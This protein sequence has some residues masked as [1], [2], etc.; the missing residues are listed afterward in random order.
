LKV[1]SLVFFR[2]PLLLAYYSDG[3]WAL[4]ASVGNYYQPSPAP[5]PGYLSKP[6]RRGRP[7]NGL[8]VTND[9]TVKKHTVKAED[10]PTDRW[11]RRRLA[12]KRLEEERRKRQPPSNIL[13]ITAPPSVTI[14]F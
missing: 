1:P 7:I 6:R 8:E 9:M 12:K 3:N 14:E 5:A 11:A 2:L 4:L 13:S 10:R